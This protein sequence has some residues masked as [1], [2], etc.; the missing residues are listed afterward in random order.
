MDDDFAAWL[1]S[2]YDF[3]RQGIVPDAN[4][5]RQVRLALCRVLT[6]LMHLS[7]DPWSKQARQ[8]ARVCEKDFT[9]G[10][11]RIVE[12]GG[13]RQNK[14]NKINED[15]REEQNNKENER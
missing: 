4:D 10:S 5:A 12:A 2:R 11:G 15:L 7:R 8:D 6:L 14:G 13:R 3:L 1:K 9:W